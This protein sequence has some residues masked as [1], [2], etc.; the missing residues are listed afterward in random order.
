MEVKPETDYLAKAGF[1]EIERDM[2]PSAILAPAIK[3]L[4]KHGK[5]IEG[6]AKIYQAVKP[7]KLTEVQQQLL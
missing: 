1:P 3:C 2:A 5:K 6:L 7:E 4:Q